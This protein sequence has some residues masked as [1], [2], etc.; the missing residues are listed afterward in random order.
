[1]DA[2]SETATT[3]YW[4]VWF[5]DAIRNVHLFWMEYGETEYEGAMSRT[6]TVEYMAKRGFAA[7]EKFSSSGAAGDLLFL[8]KASV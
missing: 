1:M 4:D 8:R 5:S 2:H 3:I 7:V 6:E